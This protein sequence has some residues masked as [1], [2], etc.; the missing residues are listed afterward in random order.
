MIYTGLTSFIVLINLVNAE[1]FNNDNVVDTEGMNNNNVMNTEGINNNN[2]MNSEGINNHSKEKTFIEKAKNYVTT[3]PGMYIAIGVCAFLALILL[4]SIILIVKKVKKRKNNVPYIEPSRQ[5]LYANENSK[6]YIS[7]NSNYCSLPIKD[8]RNSNFNIG[9]PKAQNNYNNISGSYDTLPLPG[10]LPHPNNSAIIP[11]IRINDETL[12][13]NYSFGRKNIP[14]NQFGNSIPM[15]PSF[16]VN[17]N[18]NSNMTN[19]IE[20]INNR[21]PFENRIDERPQPINVFDR[22]SNPN[23]TSSLMDEDDIDILNSYL[24]DSR[25]TID[26]DD[27]IIPNY[28][29]QKNIRNEENQKQQP[30]QQPKQQQQQQQQ[31]QQQEEEQYDIPEKFKQ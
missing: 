23:R 16:N 3:K 20:D 31:K 24:N 10:S 15:Q 26:E 27:N 4:F 25:N 17:P 14:I 11:K 9:I 29:D 19:E 7:D 18:I 30:K 2:V 8:M 22:E 5:E 6:S 12:K 28:Y 13:S 1:G 21:P